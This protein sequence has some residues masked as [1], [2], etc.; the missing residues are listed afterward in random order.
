MSILKKIKS[1]AR[2]ETVYE[3]VIDGYKYNVCLSPIVEVLH[4]PKSEILE[5]MLITYKFLN[6]NLS[7]KDTL[8]FIGKAE[9]VLNIKFGVELIEEL[10]EALDECD[11]D[12]IVSELKSP[13]RTKNKK[14]IDTTLEGMPLV[15]RWDI[16]KVMEYANLSKGVV[17][18]YFASMKLDKHDRTTYKIMDA[19]EILWEQ[20]VVKPSVS[21][22]CKTARVSR[23]T[24]YK[25]EAEDLDRTNSRYTE[26][27]QEMTTLGD[28][29]VEEEMV[30]S[31]H[32]D[33]LGYYSDIDTH[34]TYVTNLP[35]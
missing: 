5:G 30:K 18:R 33:D 15:D 3:A 35:F 23:D 12:E 11:V 22:I 21:K 4:C 28:Y 32:S 10:I 34:E 14:T 19:L 29:I 27:C 25:R 13:F 7:Y 26:K 9:A 20:G 8:W 6:K 31:L 1:K 16:K 24:Y 17:D 2:T